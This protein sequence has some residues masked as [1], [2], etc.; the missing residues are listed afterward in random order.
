MKEASGKWIE[1]FRTLYASKIPVY[2][3]GCRT[4]GDMF[5]KE[6]VHFLQS[7]GATPQEI[8]DFVEDWCEDGEPDLES[9][10]ALTGIRREYF[11]TEQQG[12]YSEH[13]IRT[14][15]L[16]GRT[17]ALA[18]LEWFPRIIEKAKA[19]LRGELPPD[20]MYACAGDRRFL[21][22]VH[23]DPVEFLREVRKAGDNPEPLIN[24]VTE[25]VQG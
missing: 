23:V 2:Q 16:P 22:R 12:Q 13:M 7:I 19:K 9:V 1:I 5:S 21:R 20:L 24:F 6:E 25:R 10:V 4:A 3:G 17:A 14:G 18:G 11:L 8:F 15:D